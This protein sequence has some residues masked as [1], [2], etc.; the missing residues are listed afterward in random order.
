MAIR[1]P[2]QW[3]MSQREIDAA[4]ARWAA[5]ERVKAEY[6]RTARADA[7]RADQAKAFAQNAVDLEVDNFIGRYWENDGKSLTPAGVAYA[8]KH[9]T[10]PPDNAV[11]RADSDGLVETITR[12]R[13]GREISTFK[14][15]DGR[16][17]WMDPFRAP[18][19]LMVAM[20]NNTKNTYKQTQQYLI[21]H[22]EASL[23]L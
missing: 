9:G 2:S 6:T 8:V 20:T 12:D 13:T 18:L 17:H 4:A 10:V 3:D 19:G 7:V 1:K 14:S 11:I 15:V 21:D 22:P 5:G 23:M 16:K